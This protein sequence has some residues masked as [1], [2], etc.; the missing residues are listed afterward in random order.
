MNISSVY[1]KLYKILIYILKPEDYEDS[2]MEDEEEDIDYHLEDTSSSHSS[3]KDEG[4]DPCNLATLVRL[5]SN[6]QQ[7]YL[8]GSISGSVQATDRLMKELRLIIIFVKF[9]LI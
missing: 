6:Q 5:K 1:V 8:R 2:E 3:P 7:D 4:I 9:V